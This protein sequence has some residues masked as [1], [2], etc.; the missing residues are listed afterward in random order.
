M[1]TQERIYAQL[2]K[3]SKKKFSKQKV[4]LMIRES[5]I[6]EA[7]SSFRNERGN[8]DFILKNE[9]PEIIN[10]L[11]NFSATIEN[12]ID[13]LNRLIDLYKDIQSEY[14]NKASELGIDPNDIVDYRFL[15]TSIFE[16]E[17]QIEIANN[18]LNSI[19]SL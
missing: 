17:E 15:D 5:E 10:K 13:E 11:D 18:L 19:S 2:S 1:T 9:L 8:L 14:E 4:N 12:S 7:S 16:A 6:D 3:N